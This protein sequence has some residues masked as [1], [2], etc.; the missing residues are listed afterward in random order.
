M[1]RRRDRPPP[2]VAI[3]VWSF[4]CL[5]SVG[6]G[7]A[8]VTGLFDDRSADARGL[9]FSFIGIGIAAFV[10]Q[11]LIVGLPRKK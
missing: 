10:G 3:V 11:F 6:L 8:L 4:L 2:L 7:V 1:V 5:L 9:G